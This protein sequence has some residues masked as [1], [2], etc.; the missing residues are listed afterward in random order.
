M[1]DTHNGVITPDLLITAGFIV[2]SRLGGANTE[3]NPVFESESCVL[4]DEKKGSRRRS[5]RSITRTLSIMNVMLSREN[6]PITL[7][8][9]SYER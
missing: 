4:S 2:E 6:N 5:H 3:E 1:L 8:T 9:T 7:T